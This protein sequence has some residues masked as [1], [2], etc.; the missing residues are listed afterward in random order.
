MDMTYLFYPRA[1]VLDLT[2][3]DFGNYHSDLCDYDFWIGLN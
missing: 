1:T 2:E 3:S